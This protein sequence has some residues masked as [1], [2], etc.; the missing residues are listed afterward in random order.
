MS[1]LPETLQK[2]LVRL[3]GGRDDL[4]SLT[5][6]E[7]DRIAS[8][9]GLNSQDLTAIEA[10][11]SGASRL[12]FERLQSLGLSGADVERLASGLLRDFERTCSCCSDKGVC[13]SDLKNDASSKEWHAYCPNAEAIGAV[14][15]AKGRFPL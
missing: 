11:G 3:A 4:N 15:A 7:R 1:I 6:A 8:D 2:L 10:K 9:L 5:R 13:A 14:A 12:L